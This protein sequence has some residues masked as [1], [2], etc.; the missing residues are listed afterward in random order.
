MKKFKFEMNNNRVDNNFYYSIWIMLVLIPFCC[1]AFIF[2]DYIL[3]DPSVFS[4]W[5]VC[6]FSSSP[7]S[8][9]I[10]CCS[11]MVTCRSYLSPGFQ[12]HK[13][14]YLPDRSLCMYHWDLKPKATTVRFIFLHY[15]Y[16]SPYFILLLFSN[17][18]SDIFFHY[19]PSY[20]LKIH[21]RLSSP[22]YPFAH[23][24]F[25][26]IF[27]KFFEIDFVKIHFCCH[28]L[29]SGPHF[30]TWMITGVSWLVTRITFQNYKPEYS[31]LLPI[32]VPCFCLTQQS[33]T[34]TIKWKL[35][36]VTLASS[37]A[38]SYSTLL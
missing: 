3:G 14:A 18:I 10:C 36:S 31:S 16:S 23:Q 33:R 22:S 12:I 17:L 15:F 26:I 11:M 29:S 13:L 4:I 34:C 21:S 27:L 32:S 8:L 30:Y 38:S 35:F 7:M 24:E 25:K 5:S 28:C 19:L 6:M 2:L 9:F 1:V 20:K 37:F